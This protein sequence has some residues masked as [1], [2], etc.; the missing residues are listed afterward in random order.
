MGRKRK[1]RNKSKWVS[2]RIPKSMEKEYR[3]GLRESIEYESKLEK[4]REKKKNI[5]SLDNEKENNIFT[6]KRT[7]IECNKCGIC[8]EMSPDQQRWHSQTFKWLRNVRNDSD[9]AEYECICGNTVKSKI[10]DIV[11]EE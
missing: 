6:E 7:L 9:T 8:E 4:F 5:G 2:V 1:F 11:I 10:E 3:K